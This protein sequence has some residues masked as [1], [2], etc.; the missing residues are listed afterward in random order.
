MFIL[1]AFA[2]EISPEPAEQIKVLKACGVRHIEFRSIHKT[3]VL[4]LTDLQIAEFKDLLAKEGIKLSAIGSPI[5]KI[6]IDEPFEPH[7]EKF[8]RAIHLCKVFG[9]PNIRIFSYYPPENFNGDWTPHRDEVIRRMKA[10][11]EIAAKNGVMLFHENEHRI[12]GDSPERLADLF[13]S[14]PSPHLKAAFDPANFIYCGYDVMK[15]W[16][17]CKPHTAHFHIKD[18]KTGEP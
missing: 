9:T 18:W 17:V 7:L 4:A 10:K 13:A 6:R 8:Q 15:G 12:F 11:V 16:E 1:S 2:D 3:N 14:V 5:G